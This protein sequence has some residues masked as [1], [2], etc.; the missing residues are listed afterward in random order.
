L[1]PS[2]PDGSPVAGPPSLATSRRPPPGDQAPRAAVPYAGGGGTPT[3]R[4][5]WLDPVLRAVPGVARSFWYDMRRHLRFGGVFVRGATPNAAAARLTKAAHSIEKGL[6]LPEPRPGFGPPAVARLRTHLADYVAR[7]GRDRTAAIAARTLCAYEDFN[8]RQDLAASDLPEFLAALGFP[9]GRM[10]DEGGVR[11]LRREEVLRHARIDFDAF[12]RHRFSIRHF[13]P[14]P[15]APALV[16][17]AVETALFT[18]SVCNR[19]GWRVHLFHGR[20][21]VSRALSFQNGNRGFGH[22]VDTLLLVSADLE[23]FSVNGERNQGWIDGGLFCMSL[24]FALHS[25]GLGTC[26]LNC[27][28][29]GEGERA[30]RGALGVPD[31]EAVVMMIA[32]GHLSGEFRVTHSARK[33]VE[34]VL[35]VH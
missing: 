8:R 32:V 15:V 3:R 6:S 14:E 21:Q 22:E 1:S 7:F 30:L 24:V 17:R 18:P 34:D 10:G 16:E 20:E 12:A 19:Q 26:M 4:A 29:S 23:S 27:S 5:V 33:A 31:S 13:A 9:E 35:V 2:S 11:E 28:M 25:L